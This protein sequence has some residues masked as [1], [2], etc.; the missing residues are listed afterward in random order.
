MMFR[1]CLFALLGA[2]SLTSCAAKAP[3][4]AAAGA[5]A[6]PPARVGIAASLP[7]GPVDEAAIRRSVEKAIPGVKIDR[8]QASPI[9]GYREVVLSGRVVYVSNDGR[10]LMQGSLIRLG[11]RA[12]LTDQSEAVLR[13]AV[14]AG[15]GP[16]RRIEFKATGT[17]RH[18]ITVFTDIDCA[19]C[20]KLHSQIADYNKAGITVDYLFF[21]RAGLDS[22]SFD[23]AVAV[24]CAPDRQAALTAAKADRPVPKRT[25]A[26]PIAA[27]FALG[28]QVGVDGTPAIYLDDGTQIGGYLAPQDMLAKLDE[29]AAAVA[30]RTA[31]AGN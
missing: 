25:C 24:W 3:G 4:T 31:L 30:T 16:E 27:E 17:Q 23:K 18:R 14:L 1:S 10:Y 11:D 22:E 2:L 20:R 28:H 21:P 5:T 6:T 9:A 29:H 19:Y 12:N 13:R 7:A 8:I 26:N 15:V